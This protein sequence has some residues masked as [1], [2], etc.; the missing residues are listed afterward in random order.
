MRVAVHK[1][2]ENCRWACKKKIDRVLHEVLQFATVMI[3]LAVSLCLCL[4]HSVILFSNSSLWDTASSL[5]DMRTANVME[6]CAEEVPE[7]RH[8]TSGSSSNLEVLHATEQEQDRQNRRQRGQLLH[9]DERTERIL[10]QTVRSARRAAAVRNVSET[11]PV[12][13]QAPN[14]SERTYL[15]KTIPVIVTEKSLKK[16]LDKLTGQ[17][18]ET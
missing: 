3:F 10:T 6:M 13:V 8:Q 4:E 11:T 1:V 18:R 2:E 7:A 17:R 9:G 15:P 16:A 14:F 5:P 12:T